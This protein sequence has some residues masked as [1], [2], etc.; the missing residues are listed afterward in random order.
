MVN[1]ELVEEIERSMYVDDLISGGET[2][3]TN[4]RNQDAE[5]QRWWGDNKTNTRNQGDSHN[6]LW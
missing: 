4:I 2:T 5:V 6:N 3:K 1:L